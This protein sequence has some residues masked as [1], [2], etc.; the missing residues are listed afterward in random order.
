[1]NGAREPR[2]KSVGPIVSVI[3]PTKNSQATIDR[4]L[5]S[6]RSQ[7]YMPVEIIVVDNF[8]TD[9]TVETAR[10]YADMVLLVGPERTAQVNT[11]IERSSGAFVCRLESDMELDPDVI[12]KCVKEMGQSQM[13]A[14][15]IPELN[16]GFTFW[17]RCRELEKRIYVHDATVEVPRFFR[18]ETIF[19]V[20]LYD[21]NLVL[22]EDYDLKIRLGRSKA[23]IG[24]IEGS[25]ERHL[26]YTDL[27]KLIAGSFYYG[28][29]A[30]RFLDKY[31]RQ[32]ISD[33][34]MPRPA[35][36]RNWRAFL[37]EPLLGTGLVVMKVLQYLSTALG[38]L[39]ERFRPRK[40][41]A[42]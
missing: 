4:V 6:I 38:H 14:L 27:H 17:G 25:F 22:H 13:D 26:D 10:R 11:G 28:R 42:H 30:G 35:W 41:L 16:V 15:I 21:R 8:S 3:V 9:G 7:T 29:T 2:V 24:R 32:G 39:S 37:E 34:I 18:R 20:G 19:A 12:E 36:V 23:R 1:M 31:G 5:R 33:S 40:S